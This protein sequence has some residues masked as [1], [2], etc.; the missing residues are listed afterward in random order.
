M[1]P[2][3]AMAKKIVGNNTNSR[4]II[5][6]IKAR[7]A[8]ALSK[9]DDA[10]ANAYI[11]NALANAN[12]RLKT[13]YGRY[14]YLMRS[15]N[16]LIKQKAPPKY[17]ARLRE[18]MRD[19]H[20]K[21]IVGQKAARAAGKMREY[22]RQLRSELSIART[23]PVKSLGITPPAIRHK[24]RIEAIKQLHRERVA[25]KTP[26]AKKMVEQAVKEVQEET[27]RPTGDEGKTGAG[28]LLPGL[29][30]MGALL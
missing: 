9:V 14:L 24:A 10:T 12:T 6:V 11:N 5:S 26:A 15:L 7:A 27:G 19:I 3:E 8:G 18:V 2:S 30:I 17:Q 22:Q 28:M 23:M 25:V 21:V 4:Q 13:P 1:K 16:E 29:L 20:K